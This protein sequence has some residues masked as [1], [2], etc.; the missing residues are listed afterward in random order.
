MNKKII[1]YSLLIIILTIAGFGY[2]KNP[3]KDEAQHLT[4][5]HTND[6][7]GRLAPFQYKGGQDL[8]G[9]LAR[10]ATIIKQIE[11]ANKCAVTVDAG[12]FA[13]GSLFFNTFKG[14]PDAELMSEAGY[15]VVTLGNHE[16]DRGL[17]DLKNMIKGFSI[18]VVSSNIEFIEN[19]EI[20]SLIKPYTITNCHGLKIGFMGLVPK[21][22]KSLTAPKNYK[23]YD[24]VETTR[25]VVKKL[26][27]HVDLMVVISHMGI[28]EDLMLAKS[29]EEVDVIVGGHSHTLI[30]QPKLFHKNGDKTLVVQ[31]GELGVYL[32][33]LDLR[34]KD[35]KIEDY[36]YQL[37]PINEEIEP[38]IGIKNKI[39]VLSE[40][41]KANT[42]EIIGQIEI[43]LGIDGE[44]IRKKLLPSGSLVTEAIKAKISDVDIVLQNSGGIRPYKRLGPG[45]ITKADIARLYPFENTIVTLELKG[46]DLKSVLET[47]SKN[48]PG[49]SG[50][51]LQSLGLQYTVDTSK[52][53]GKRVSNILVNN[54]PL[55]KNKLYR[56][57]INDFMYKGGNEYTQFKNATKH[58][59]TN[60]MIQ[61]T[62]IDYI[63]QNSPISLEVR[64]KITIK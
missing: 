40:Q 39:A 9:G 27:P 53:E 60:F 31:G 42:E 30:N 45:A 2:Y 13:Q 6:V 5:L 35:K 4:I 25:Q 21:D 1:L 59:D 44:N 14:V 8:V 49:N 51:F 41:I 55:E 50:G 58:Y 28:K 33:R 19:P 29:V 48:L 61:D 32:G 18:P 16:F 10:R 34:F 46:R 56:I 23:L 37:I 15:D 62:I 3:W 54:A 12:D 11:G 64:D 57:A 26:D 22:L 17:T 63:R 24:P 38:D 20:Q 43:P 36:Y 47:S 7:H 52:E